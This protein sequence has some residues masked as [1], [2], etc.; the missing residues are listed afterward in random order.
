MQTRLLIA[1]LLTAAFAAAL[2]SA[3]DE[4]AIT[5]DELVRRTQEIDDAVA[6][7]NQEPFKKYFADDVLYFDEKGRGMDK[8]ALVKD[9]QP[10][11]Q[12]YS[13]T[14][15][16]MRPK[17]HIENNIAILSYDMDETEIVFGQN[18]TARYHETDTWMWREGKWQVVAAQVLRYYEDPAA[19]KADPSKFAAYIGTYRLGPER[20]MVVTSENGQL[21]SQRNGRPKEELVPE[22]SDIFFRKGV[23]GRI[24]FSHSD[25][26]K[27]ETLIDRRNNE[28]IV[29]KK[30]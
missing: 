24:L 9:V 23:E 20:T 28:D 25:D 3:A 7:G 27:V 10:L 18:L 29:W 8:N 17:S 19:G 1:V 30:K 16:V 5:Q 14:I 13:G 11:P 12:G 4:P 2:H 15:K 21:F 22:A 6:S 26:G